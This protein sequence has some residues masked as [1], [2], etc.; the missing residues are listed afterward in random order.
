MLEGQANKDNAINLTL[1]EIN[2]KLEGLSRIEK[3][4]DTLNNKLDV[5]ASLIPNGTRK[6]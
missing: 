4:I 6:W 2:R 5:I 1:R 3:M